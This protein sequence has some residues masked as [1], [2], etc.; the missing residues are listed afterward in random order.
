MSNFLQ[1]NPTVTKCTFG[2]NSAYLGGG[3][4][5][6]LSGLVVIDCMFSG[7]SASNGGG[8]YTEAA[9]G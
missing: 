7:N 3:I 6:Y 1:S 5:N 4:Y 9:H 8:M 2:A